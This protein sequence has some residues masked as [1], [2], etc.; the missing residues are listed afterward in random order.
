VTGHRVGARL[1][2][3]LGFTGAE[4]PAAGLIDDQSRATA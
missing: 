3:E 4:E 2:E 1:G